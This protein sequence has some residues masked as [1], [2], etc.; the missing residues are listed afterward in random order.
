MLANRPIALSL[1]AAAFI[2]QGIE[3]V[4]GMIGSFSFGKVNIN[5]MFLLL[6]AGIGL[7]QLSDGWR[8]FTLACLGLVTVVMSGMVVFE[9]FRPGKIPVTWFGMV[10]SGAPRYVLFT[11]IWIIAGIVVWWAYRT[12]THPAIV[13]LFKKGPDHEPPEPTAM[14]VTPP[15]AQ[16]PR[17]P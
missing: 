1:I 11:I 10:T 17:Q 9:V 7:L 14:S 13:V 15:A 3:A 6:F 16:E 5:L 8:K 2:F 12:L 4:V